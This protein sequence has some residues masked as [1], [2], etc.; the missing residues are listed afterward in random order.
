MAMVQESLEE[1]LSGQKSHH[2][3]TGLPIL[4]HLYTCSLFMDYP[5]CMIL[6]ICGS[7]SHLA[8]EQLAYKLNRYKD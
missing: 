7:F 3:S 4:H 6:K 8:E 5:L 1:N 2:E